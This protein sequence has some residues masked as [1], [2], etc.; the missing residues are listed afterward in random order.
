[1]TTNRL[2]RMNPYKSVSKQ[3]SSIDTMREKC[4]YSE[5]FRS[6]FPH[7]WTRIIPNTDT[8]YA[9]IRTYLTFLFIQKQ[10]Y[11]CPLKKISSENSPTSQ[12]NT[13]NGL[14]FQKSFV[15]KVCNSTSRRSP[16][17]VFLYDFCEKLCI[18]YRK[19]RNVSYMIT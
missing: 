13:C 18:L 5:L 16:S 17:E 2:W 6:T 3:Y 10:L 4:P 15:L 1:M 19:T 8:F 9:A 12:V 14:L 7:I 11:E